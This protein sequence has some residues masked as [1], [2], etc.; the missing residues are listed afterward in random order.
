MDTNKA[1]NQ[2]EVAKLNEEVVGLAQDLRATVRRLDNLL[3]SRQR[4]IEA[5]ILGLRRIVENI[6]ALSEDAKKNPSRVLF[7]SPPPRANPGEQK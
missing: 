7:G 4:D 5:L 1:I 2:I 3:A 6:T